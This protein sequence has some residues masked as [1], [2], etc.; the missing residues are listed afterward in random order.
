MPC[1]PPPISR[2]PPTSVAVRARPDLGLRQDRPGRG[3][4]ARSPT[5]GVE[6][7]STGGTRKAIADAGL[8]VKDV[9][10]LTG[11]PEMMD[12]RVKTLH[13]VVHGGLLGVRDAPEPQ[14][15]DGRARDRRRSTWSTSTSTRSRRPWPRARDYETCVENIDIGGPA[16]IRSAAKNHG[17]V[18]VCTEPAD[19]AEVLAELADGGA[20]IAG[21]AQAP[22]GPRLRPHR[23]L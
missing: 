14:G 17:Y 10:D 22:G 18:A 6:L 1:P 8:P 2:P 23:R 20:T 7:V 16:M 3:R 21:A 9:S 12:G 11:F 19:M 13:P 4:P 5:L 15:G